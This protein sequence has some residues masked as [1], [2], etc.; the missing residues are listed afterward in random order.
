MQKKMF[1]K[2]HYN[3][4]GHAHELTVSCFKGIPFFNDTAACDRFLT[5]LYQA[6]I[7]FSFSIWAYVIM[8]QHIHILIFPN[9]NTYDIKKITKSL[10]GRIAKKYMTTLKQMNNIPILNKCLAKEK[11]V[12]KHRFWQIGGGF[13]RN[14]WNVK[15]I[16]D[17]IEYIENNPV[18]KKLVAAPEEWRWSSA[19]ARKMKTGVIPDIFNMPVNQPN[20][21]KQKLGKI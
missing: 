10:H 5:E 18:R 2:T 17:S 4:P 14:I 8:P 15:A 1:K 7:D 21:Q 3:T 6:K 12:E 16:Y 20:P 11:G 13:D 9:E 19:Y